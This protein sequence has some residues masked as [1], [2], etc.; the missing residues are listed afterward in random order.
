MGFIG[1]GIAD[2][3][4]W[5][6][7][8]QY[9]LQRTKFH[10]EFDCNKL[11]V[12]VR[13]PFEVILSNAHSH[14]THSYSLKADVDLKNDE[15]KYWDS[16]IKQQVDELIIFWDFMMKIFRN[17]DV[18]AFYLKYEDLKNK[19]ALSDVCKYILN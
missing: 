13:D 1:E 14:L 8:S 18:P 10:Q 11:I 19:E 9:P 2:K 7:E 16:F 4:V 17:R 3:S 6:I 15:K 5:M 12:L